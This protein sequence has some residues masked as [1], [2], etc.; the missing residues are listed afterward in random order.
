[1]KTK[2]I[3]EIIVELASEERRDIFVD[4]RKGWKPLGSTKAVIELEMSAAIFLDNCPSIERVFVQTFLIDAKEDDALTG[5][6]GD[7]GKVMNIHEVEGNWITGKSNDGRYRVQVKAF[8]EGSDG[9]QGGRVSKLD[10]RKLSGESVAM[11]DRGWIVRPGAR[12]K[13]RALCD[14]IVGALR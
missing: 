5:D 11:Y 3:T 4:S 1:M 7:L 10:I 2:P 14:S 6:L 13:D 12:T 8:S 9:I